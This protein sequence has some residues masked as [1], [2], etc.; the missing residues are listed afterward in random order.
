ML[1]VHTSLCIAES[2]MQIQRNFV[3]SCYFT[4][5]I[6]YVYFLNSIFVKFSYLF[7]SVVGLP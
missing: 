7:G 1:S 5:Y 4:L 2:E 3:F 6:S